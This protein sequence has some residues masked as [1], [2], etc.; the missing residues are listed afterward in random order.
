MHFKKL[1]LLQLL[2]GNLSSS[3]IL[4]QRLAILSE[5]APMVNVNRSK[6]IKGVQLC[7]LSE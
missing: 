6:S 5:I 1:A 4:R 7:F 3:K 2:K